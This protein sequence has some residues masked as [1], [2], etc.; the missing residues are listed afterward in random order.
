MTGIAPLEPRALVYEPLTGLNSSVVIISEVHLNSCMCEKVMP[1]QYG[2]KITNLL[3]LSTMVNTIHFRKNTAS[4]VGR[5]VVD[6]GTTPRSNVSF[7]S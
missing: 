1:S 2:K 7:C 4:P 3:S 5:V 6:I